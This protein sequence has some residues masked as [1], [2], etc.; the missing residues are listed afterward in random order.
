[1]RNILAYA[2]EIQTPQ[3]APLFMKAI[4][5]R[6]T[7]V[8]TKLLYSLSNH[9]HTIPA[10]HVVYRFRVYRF[11]IL[12]GERETMEGLIQLRSETCH[13]DVVLCLQNQVIW[14]IPRQIRT[15]VQRELGLAVNLIMSNASFPTG[16]REAVGGSSVY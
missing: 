13:I 10:L 11:P 4:H 16:S 8:L 7:Y 5:T 6:R 1:M 9:L 12:K 14:R 2:L 15:S 3:V